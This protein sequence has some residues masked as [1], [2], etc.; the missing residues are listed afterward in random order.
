MR[1]HPCFRLQSAVWIGARILFQKGKGRLGVA[2]DKLLTRGFEGDDF[3]GERFG[4]DIDSAGMLAL[5][6]ALPTHSGG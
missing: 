2:A 1:K 3:D 4:T 5:G 6:P